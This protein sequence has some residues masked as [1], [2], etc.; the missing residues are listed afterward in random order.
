QG[1]TCFLSRLDIPPIGE[2]RAV[3]TALVAPVALVVVVKQRSQLAQSPL[4]VTGISRAAPVVPVVLRTG[5]EINQEA[6][7]LALAEVNRA[8]LGQA[9]QNPLIPLP[10]ALRHGA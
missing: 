2:H 8:I 9:A 7:L 3:L 10:P 6:A 5:T 4:L 1:E